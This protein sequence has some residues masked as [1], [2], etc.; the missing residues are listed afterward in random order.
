M[1][2]YLRVSVALVISAMLS[3][4]TMAED[5]CKVPLC[6]FGLLKGEKD[7]TCSSAISSYFGILVYKKGKVSW[8]KTA[9]KRL[10]A[11]QSC[12]SADRD[13]I[14]EVNNKFGRSRG[15]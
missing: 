12:P 6:M 15:G 14:K 3:T 10:S 11:L 2:K 7:S 13:K 1:K 9:K 4:P 8:S 5:S